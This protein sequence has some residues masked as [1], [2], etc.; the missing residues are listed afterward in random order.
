MAIEGGEKW[1]QRMQRRR[2]I[3]KKNQQHTKRPPMLQIN[4]LWKERK[5]L[6]ASDD[7]AMELGPLFDP[8]FPGW[9]PWSRLCAWAWACACA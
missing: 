8:G 6:Y 5:R 3:G 2:E 7:A 1:R 4:K 9:S